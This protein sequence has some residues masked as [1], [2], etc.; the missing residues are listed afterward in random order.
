[1]RLKSDE[2][3]GP[4]SPQVHDNAA[5]GANSATAIYAIAV[6]ACGHSNYEM[7]SPASPYNTES[8]LAVHRRNRPCRTT[9]ETRVALRAQIGARW[10]SATPQFSEI[11]TVLVVNIPCRN[12]WIS[13]VLFHAA[14]RCAVHGPGSDSSQLGNRVV[15]RFW[16]SSHFPI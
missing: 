16:K 1:M 8:N 3:W 13:Q 4:N 10:G 14:R 9:Q 12:G 2:F 7:Q 11:L 6:A 5:S 15:S